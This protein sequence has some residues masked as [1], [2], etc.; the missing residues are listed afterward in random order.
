MTL[1]DVLFI[2]ALMLAV[3]NLVKSL[4]H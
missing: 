4:K 3:A 1:A 2:M